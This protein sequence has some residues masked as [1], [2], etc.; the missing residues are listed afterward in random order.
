MDALLCA[1]RRCIRCSNDAFKKIDVIFNKIIKWPD[2]GLFPYF[3][4]TPHSAF[5]KGSIHHCEYIPKGCN[6][7]HTHCV[8]FVCWDF[9]NF[10][11]SKEN[12]HVAQH[13]LFIS[14]WLNRLIV[15]VTLNET[16]VVTSTVRWNWKKVATVAFLDCF[17]FTSCKKVYTRPGRWRGK[18][19]L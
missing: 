7:V 12:Y 8:I 3:C 10:N 1:A 18:G 9:C 4:L 17:S 11:E 16:N 15:V 5:V 6:N 13:T 14:Y 2:T 19:L